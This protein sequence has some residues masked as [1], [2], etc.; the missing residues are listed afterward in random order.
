M[1]YINCIIIAKF[2]PYKTNLID[3]LHYIVTLY[4]LY[5][6]CS[7]N[8]YSACY[9]HNSYYSK[10]FPKLFINSIAINSKSYS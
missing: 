5:A 9:M 4:M 6:A 10:Q 2:L 3:K 1:H 8:N 7:T